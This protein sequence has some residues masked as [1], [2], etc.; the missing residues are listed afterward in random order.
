MEY[1]HPAS[2]PMAV[3]D[4]LVWYA[5]N[6]IGRWKHTDTSK[7]KRQRA[8]SSSIFEN[9]RLCWC[10]LFTKQTYKFSRTSMGG[11]WEEAK[12]IGHHDRKNTWCV[13]EWWSSLSTAHEEVT[14]QSQEE[15]CISIKKTWTLSRNGLEHL[16]S[17]RRRKPWENTKASKETR[18]RREKGDAKAIPWLDLE[19][20]ATWRK[21]G[22]KGSQSTEGS[23][24]KGRRWDRCVYRMSCRLQVLYGWTGH[25]TKSQGAQT[26][27]EMSEDKSMRR[28]RHLQKH[29][30]SKKGSR[31]QVWSL[32]LP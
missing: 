23:K 15:P 16:L 13:G 2:R 5:R 26:E 14:K 18:C 1:H 28:K 24:K 19:P 6:F 20:N 30:R 31:Q 4:P 27:K 17:T 10:S 9:S 12:W 3:Q 21:R 29:S 25:K 7:S 22:C 8:W 32:I 11:T